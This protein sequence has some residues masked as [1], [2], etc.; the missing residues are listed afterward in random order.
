[1]KT[2]DG[3]SREVTSKLTHKFLWTVNSTKKIFPLLAL[4]LHLFPTAVQQ[5]LNADAVAFS[6]VNLV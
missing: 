4:F 2:Y 6:I 3:T 1:M 5:G